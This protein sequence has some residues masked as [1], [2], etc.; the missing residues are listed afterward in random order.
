MKQ[1]QKLPADIR[2][3]LANLGEDIRHARL[4]REIPMD[5]LARLAGTT[6]LTLG[7][8]ERGAP[9]VSIGIYA[10]VLYQLGLL[11]ALGHVAD[12]AYDIEGRKLAIKPLPMRGRGAKTR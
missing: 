12:P 8:V 3:S 11:D 4:R 5:V 9:N 7:K 2:D 6:R 1:D 10:Q